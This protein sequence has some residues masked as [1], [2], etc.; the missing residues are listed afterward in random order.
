[1]EETKK[2]QN[3]LNKIIMS[4]HN[5]VKSR[6]IKEWNSVMKGLYYDYVKDHEVNTV[7]ADPK[8]VEEM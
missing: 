6:D 7:K 4:I 2:H 5:C 8:G 1:V 3:K